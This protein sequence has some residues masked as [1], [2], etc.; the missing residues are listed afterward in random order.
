[1]SDNPTIRRAGFAFVT[2]HAV[3]SLWDL[4]VNLPYP[5]TVRLMLSKLRDNFGIAIKIK[6]DRMKWFVPCV[7]PPITQTPRN[8]SASASSPISFWGVLAVPTDDKTLDRFSYV[9]LTVL[10]PNNSIVSRL[11]HNEDPGDLVE[12]YIKFKAD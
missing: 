5:E 10:H 1:M 4:G 8:P 11:W 12:N 3:E 7:V 2:T 9:V 6:Q